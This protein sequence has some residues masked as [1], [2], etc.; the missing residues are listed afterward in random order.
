VGRLLA[1]FREKW[2]L[3]HVRSGSRSILAD[4]RSENMKSVI[5]IKIKNR[6][7]FRPFAPSVLQDKSSEWFD[8][9]VK[10]P[11]MSFV[12]YLNKDKCFD[13]ETNSNDFR[14][15]AK[16]KVKRSQVPAITHVDNSARVQTVSADSDSIVDSMFCRL[17]TSFEK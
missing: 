17:L 8:M 16:L 3:I 2:S 5:N 9:K 6:E 11:Y 1:G 4:P 15:L 7:S 14:G 10:S 13:S 12:S